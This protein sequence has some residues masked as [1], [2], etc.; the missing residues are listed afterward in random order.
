[1]PLRLVF[2]LLFHSLTGRIEVQVVVYVPAASRTVP[3]PCIDEP[4]RKRIAPVK[5]DGGPVDKAV[6]EML[7][8]VRAAADIESYRLIPRL[9]DLG[10]RVERIV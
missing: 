3:Q 9:E 2:P 10:V 5:E 1:L 4:C 8:S 7:G 6:G